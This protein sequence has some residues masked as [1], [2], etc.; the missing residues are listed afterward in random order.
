M[1]NRLARATQRRAAPPAN[2]QK[3]KRESIIMEMIML[4]VFV[5]IAAVGAFFLLFS[6]IKFLIKIMEKKED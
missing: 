5:P 3:E 2:Y 1:D 6:G 4:F